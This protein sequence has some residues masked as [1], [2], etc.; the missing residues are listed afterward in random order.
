M[1]KIDV[2]LSDIVQDTPEINDISIQDVEGRHRYLANKSGVVRIAKDQY[3][4]DQRPVDAYFDLMVPLYKTAKNSRADSPDKFLEG[5]IRVHLSRSF[6]GHKVRNL[7]MDSATVAVISFLFVFELL[8]LL[9]LYMRQGGG[10]SDGT[11]GEPTGDWGVV[12]P[13]SF[14]FLL[15]VSL[16]HSFIPL[17]MQEIYEPFLGLSK[18]VALAL[19]ISVEMLTAGL[20]LIPVGIWLDRRGWFQPLLFG[21][22][23]S[24]VGSVLSGLAA[25]TSAYILARSIAGIG[26]GITWISAQGF[27]IQCTRPNARAQGISNLVAGLFAGQICGAA[28]GGM[29]AERMGYSKVFMLASLFFGLLF[30]ISLVVMRN[31]RTPK[32]AASRSPLSFSARPVLRFFGHRKVIAALFFSVVPLN[33][34]IVGLLYYFS[35]L[36]LKSLGSTQSDIGRVL[37][38]FGLFSIYVAP[39]VS[40]A[41]DRSIH[42]AYFIIFSGLIGSASF[43]ILGF[44]SGFGVMVLAVTLLGFASSLGASAQ[45]IYILNS[46]A[47]EGIGPG[48]A[49]S[50]QR[51]VDKLGQMLGPLILG[52]LISSVGVDTGLYA[53]GLFYFGATVLFIVLTWS[54]GSRYCVV[55]NYEF[56]FIRKMTNI[57][58]MVTS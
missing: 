10:S 20:S 33:F 49:L 43:L 21:I 53:V 5:W 42:K 16:S 48:K 15:A 28:L 46:R 11:P 8:F 13:I 30:F 17:K 19:P 41:V 40:K 50:I 14:I 22:A 23:A 58:L 55:M 44:A 52:A 4:R 26:Y 27:V 9:M 29:L 1:V 47:A 51:T 32:V 38:I 7:I 37:M 34:C 35:P 56:D 45:T 12:R 18:N 36:Y 25:S 6:I 39:Y 31:I 24:T 2:Q 57:S 54:A 3:V